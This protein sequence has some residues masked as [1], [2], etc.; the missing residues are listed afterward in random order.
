MIAALEKG[1]PLSYTINTADQVQVELHHDRATRR[2]ATGYYC[3]RN[4]AAASTASATCGPASAGRSTPTSCRSKTASDDGTSSARQ[5]RSNVAN[6]LGIDFAAGV[7]SRASARSPSASAASTPLE[8]AAAYAA[9]AGERHVLRADPGHVDHRHQRQ[10][11]RRRAAAV[12]PGD[13]PG[14]RARR[15]WTRRGARS[16]TSRP[17]TQCHYA[18]G[19]HDTRSVM[20]PPGR[21]Q[22]R[23]H[24]Q[25][26]SRTSL[27]AMT[28]QL[29]VAGILT[30]PDYDHPDGGTRSATSVNAAVATRSQTAM[31]GLP[32]LGWP[33][34][35][36]RCSQRH[37]SRQHPR[38]SSARP[39]VRRGRS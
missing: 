11:A 38:R 9:V 14:R 22:D 21:R 5:R 3:P 39:S 1:V 26:R 4:A 29:A 37:R 27:I 15:A 34:P 31:K 12:P 7:T 36:D 19:R 35:A 8:M 6:E 23:H 24:R 10:Q 16:A 30:D 13:R 32:K 25:R 2:P 20:R 17:R 28:P 18:H 33:K